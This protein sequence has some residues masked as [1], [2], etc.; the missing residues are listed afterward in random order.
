MQSIT[1]RSNDTDTQI[2]GTSVGDAEKQ[3]GKQT[4]Y[5]LWKTDSFMKPKEKSVN[6]SVKVFS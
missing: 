6:L 5:S 3:I 1:G 2:G 4:V